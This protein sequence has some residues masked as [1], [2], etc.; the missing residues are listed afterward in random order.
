MKL[1]IDF[2]RLC[3]RLDECLYFLQLTVVSSLKSR[4]VMKDELWV[5]L[6]GE[7]A[8]DIMDTALI[9]SKIKSLVTKAKIITA[10]VGSSWLAMAQLE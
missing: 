10:E 7:W 2:G 1:I 5:T 6:K 4:R 9:T 8:I 3:T